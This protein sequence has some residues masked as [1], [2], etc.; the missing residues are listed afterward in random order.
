MSL[1]KDSINQ[2]LIDEYLDE[3]RSYMISPK[4]QN[5]YIINTSSQR[6]DK[7]EI[8]A[9][10]KNLDIISEK[11]KLLYQWY[12]TVLS[13]TEHNYWKS[14]IARGKIPHV[15]SIHPYDTKDELCLKITFIT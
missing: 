10:T 9:E 15:K 11:K 2:H 7:V 13:N 1:L 3:L 4:F 12:N 6:L 14:L 5:D 8:N